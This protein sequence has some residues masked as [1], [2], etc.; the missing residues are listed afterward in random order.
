MPMTDPQESSEQNASLEAENAALRLD[1]ARLRR[2]LDEEGT[3]DRL[4]HAFRDTVAMLRAVMRRTADNSADVED[5]HAHLTG[6]LDAIVRT[7]ALTD[8][9]GEADLRMLI[10]DAL[11]TYLVQEGERATLDGPEVRL[12]PRAAQVLTL[13]MHELAT[14]AVE[15]G[16]LSGS[17]G[18][19][20]VLWRIE[21]IE[22]APTLALIWKET[23]AQGSVTPGRRGFG[24]DVLEEMVVYDLRGQVS[25]SYEPDGLR[26]AMSLP[27][28]A[29]IGRVTVD[30]DAG[31]AGERYP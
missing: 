30:E 27:L 9:F 10:A 25:L 3:P 20:S 18:G 29:R 17:A 13:A 5:Y 28:T 22:Q 15:H 6:R 16:P 19:V 31:S 8:A 1:N 12:R 7:R 11:N 26:C 4:R 14:N 21:P 2:L 24:T 23:G